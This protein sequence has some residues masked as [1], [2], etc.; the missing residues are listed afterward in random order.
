MRVPDGIFSNKYSAAPPG[1]KMLFKKRACFRSQNMI[2]YNKALF[3]SLR[4]CDTVP[5]SSSV[6]VDE[7]REPLTTFPLRT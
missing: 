7:T 2:S 6:G 1:E 3:I 4:F 5:M